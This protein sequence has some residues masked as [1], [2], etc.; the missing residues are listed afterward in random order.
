MENDNFTST[1]TA[2]CTPSEAFSF[3][4]QPNI[5]W[6]TMIS[7]SARHVA[8]SFIYEVPGIHYSKF[9]VSESLAGRRLSWQVIPSEH[10][11]ELDE[12]VGTDVIFE[13]VELS[14]GTRVDF[15]HVGLRPQLACHSVCT[16]AWGA[17]PHCRLAGTDGRG[18]G[19]SCHSEFSRRGGCRGRRPKGWV[20][21][22]R[23]ATAQSRFRTVRHP[24]WT[25]L[26][27]RPHRRIPCPPQVRIR[28]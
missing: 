8:E 1:F 19:S 22:R 9:R 10:R 3:A 16:T 20:T 17:P 12:W 2:P 27:S 25:W 15:T 24:S 14:H 21:P 4:A 26:H 7:G 11:L 23:S 28:Q 13:F 18:G 5:W 6:N